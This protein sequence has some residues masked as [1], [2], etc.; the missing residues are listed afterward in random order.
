VAVCNFAWVLAYYPDRSVAR[1]ESQGWRHYFRDESPADPVCR[2][3]AWAFRI[4]GGG[5]AQGRMVGFA[6]CKPANALVCLSA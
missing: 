2:S 4:W 1:G 3:M 5:V 6:S